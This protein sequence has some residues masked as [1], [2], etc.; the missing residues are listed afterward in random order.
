MN[1]IAFT[2]RHVFRFI[3]GICAG[4]ARRL[5][6]WLRMRF[7]AL[8][9]LV[10]I[11][12]RLL[13]RLC[14]RLLAKLLARLFSRGMAQ[15]LSKL[16]KKAIRG[17][18]LFSVL[19]L[20]SLANFFRL[21]SFRARLYFLL[22]LF[23]FSL[24]AIA[25]RVVARGI[26]HNN[27]NGIVGASK[28]RTERSDLNSKAGRFSGVGMPSSGL[29]SGFSHGLFPRATPALE[30]PTEEDSAPLHD[31]YRVI[32]RTVEGSLYATAYK[33]DI[34]LSLLRRFVD[35][36]SYDVD[37]QRDIW[38]GARFRMLLRERYRLGGDG[39]WRELEG[40]R[41]EVAELHTG[42]GISYRYYRAADSDLFYDEIARPARRLL[43]R[44]PMSGLRLTSRFGRRRH[45]VLGYTR[46]HKGVDFAAPRGTPILAAGD[47]VVRRKRY[48]R[49]G[50]GR[51][52]VLRH[53]ESLSTLYAHMRGFARGLREGVRVKQGQVIGY[54]GT[55][56]LSTG[57]HLH[58]EIH[59]NG[60][61]SN[62]RSVRLPE[63]RKLTARA[64]VLFTERRIEQDSLLVSGGEVQLPS[65][66]ARLRGLD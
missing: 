15:F 10:Y 46:L 1:N 59:L 36:M 53:N 13:I 66:L 31:R 11:Y 37:F 8:R 60:R 19:V 18:L 27:T 2:T 24:F 56:G 55:S 39:V 25:E 58:Y 62:P 17:G 65:A 30:S 23:L 42:R 4:A 43:R 45:P 22:G 38:A 5:A 51:Y 41:L 52:V 47:G 40:A 28:Q 29:F 20:S 26:A 7:F 48:S 16:C 12:T 14:Y 21:M 33:Y 44:T 54:V 35:V 63:R 61:A 9:V 50:Y 34:P 6:F 57:P 3:A 64:K 49:S 32:E